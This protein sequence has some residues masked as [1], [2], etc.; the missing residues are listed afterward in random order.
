MEILY[1]IAFYGTIIASVLSLTFFVATIIARRPLSRVL[2][3][4]AFS[5]LTLFGP[6]VIGRSASQYPT[7][8]QPLGVLGG[9][10]VGSGGFFTPPVSV[11]ETPK[12]SYSVRGTVSAAQGAVVSVKR[13][14]LG[15]TRICVA[16]ACYRSA[17]DS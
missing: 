1:K 6:W 2:Y 13:D 8:T 9:V 15:V 3:F 10:Q 14:P 17:G 5:V 12:G 11:I 7:P 4:A 16:G